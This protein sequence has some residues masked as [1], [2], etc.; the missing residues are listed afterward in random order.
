QNSF[1]VKA[2]KSFLNDIILQRG[3]PQQIRV[4]NGPEFTSKVFTTWCTGQSIIIKHI[5][6]GRSM[7]NAYIKR[8][9]RTYREDVLDV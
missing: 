9:N 8:L 4:D 1:P 5:Q 2:V 6:P 7:Q 3:K